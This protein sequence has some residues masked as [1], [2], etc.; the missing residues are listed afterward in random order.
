[1]TS[2]NLLYIFFS[3]QQPFS[4]RHTNVSCGVKKGRRIPMFRR[5]DARERADGAPTSSEGAVL[6]VSKVE[7]WG[8]CHTETRALRA[9][10]LYSNDPSLQTE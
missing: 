10:E 9:P 4:I 2:Q 8:F 1:M 5:A 6:L 7:K 3:L